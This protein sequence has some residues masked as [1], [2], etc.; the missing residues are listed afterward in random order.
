MKKFLFAAALSAACGLASAQG[1][2]GALIGL[3]QISTNSDAGESVDDTSTG[4]KVYGGYEVAPNM[5]VEVGYAS[6]GK[7]KIKVSGVNVELKS[8]ALS[9]V[10]AYRFPLAADFGGVAR[11]GLASVTGKLSASNGVV[12]VSE[13]KS[14][15]ALYAGLGLEYE[16]AK[17]I[18][19]V[20][21]FDLTKTEFQID[22]T[23]DSGTTFL[24]GAGVQAA[25]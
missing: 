25:F 2:A 1:Y 14:K 13:S 18:K 12:S 20:A 5:S 23:T 9:V 24:L 3:A 16:I 4:F 17:D 10:G 8:T 19:A 6:L 7:S 21:A 11:L 22:G 15:I